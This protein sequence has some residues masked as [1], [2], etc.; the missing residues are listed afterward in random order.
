MPGCGGG[1]KSSSASTE[2]PPSRAEAA[3]FLTQASFGPTEATVDRVVALGYRGWLAEQATFTSTDHV[4]W[5]SGRH[6]ADTAVDP[7]ASNTSDVFNAIW[8]GALSAEDQL[9]QRLAYALSQIFV[10]SMRDDGVNFRP[11]GAIG[12]YQTLANHAFGNYRDLLQAVALHPMMGIYLSHL[13]NRKEDTVTGRVPDENFAREVMQLF[14]IGLVELNIDGSPRLGKD[15]QPQDTYGSADIAGLAR[16]FTGWSWYC[17]TQSAECFDWG[18]QNGVKLP[19]APT[20]AM[21]AYPAFH[22]TAEKRFL[23]TTIAAQAN[24][25]P[26]AS[27]TVALDRLFAHPNVGPFIGR[28]LIQRLVSSNPSPAYVAR[29]AAAF[30]NN[31]LGVRGDLKAV[32]LAVLLDPEARAGGADLRGGKVKE[33]VLRVSAALRALGASS[34]SGNWRI[35]STDDPAFSIGQ[36]PLN[37]SSVFNYYRPG[38]VPPGTGAAGLGLNVPEMQIT[39]ESSVAGYANQMRDMLSQGWGSTPTGATRR[40]IQFDLTALRGVAGNRADLLAWVESRLLAGRLPAALATLI[41]DAV[42]SVAVPAVTSSNADAVAAALDNRSRIAIYLT[43]VS[44]E[45]IVQH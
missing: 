1:D 24:A 13:H 32:V 40:D 45:F 15:G 31:G 27:L 41:G 12:Y 10:I 36:T 6:A 8:R 42:D 21:V 11:L 2:A 22:S 18:S 23:G 43:L 7:T 28:Q 35:G 19:D 39:D 9:R 14:S 44:P 25:D 30:A 37:A 20:R 34:D 5:W 26:Q 29:V 4:T 3:R 38:Y 17:S 33:L 16:V